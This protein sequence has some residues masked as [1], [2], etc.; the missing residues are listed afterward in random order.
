MQPIDNGAT[1]GV[2]FTTMPPRNQDG[3]RAVF[4]PPTFV[5]DTDWDLDRIYDAQSEH[6]Q[7]LFY[8]SGLLAQW[9]R[10]D[11]RLASVLDTRAASVVGLPFVV[12]TASDDPGRLEKKAAKRLEQSWTQIVPEKLARDVVEWVTLMGFCWCQ[13]HWEV[14]PDG[15]WTPRLEPWHPMWFRYDQYVRTWQVETETGLHNIVPNQGQWVLFSARAMMPWLSGAVLSLSIPVLV[16]S[17]TWKD[18]ANFNET[19]AQAFLKGK[20]P[21]WA[22]PTTDD[23]NGSPSKTTFLAQLVGLGRDNRHILC[24]VD[25]AGNGYD[26]TYESIN[27]EGFASFEK[28]RQAADL[29]IAIRIQGQNLTTEMQSG[30]LAGSKT[31]NTVRQDIIESDCETLATD[32]HDGIAVPFAALNY[33]DGELA[34]WA[35]WNP[36]PPENNKELALTLKDLVPV[37]GTLD[38]LLAPHGLQIALPL[39][40][41]KLR[42]PVVKRTI[43][44]PQPIALP[45]AP[46]L[47]PVP[48]Q[49]RAWSASSADA[50]VMIALYPSPEIAALLALRSGEKPEHLHCT[51]AYLGR[52]AEV[53]SK[54]AALQEV[55]ARVAARA[56][57]YMAEIGGLGR[58]SNGDVDV[59][60]ASVECFG[61]HQLYRS[62]C[63]ELEEIG[64]APR[65]EHVFSPHITLAYLD[66]FTESPIDRVDRF[67]LAFAALSLVVENERLDFPFRGEWS[68]RIRAPFVR[69]MR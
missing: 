1:N 36:E 6:E 30:S 48:Q 69:S 22:N 5:P 13:L 45:T 59:L 32:T 37:L 55:V 63:S 18:W 24:E 26:A 7:G 56:R 21:A 19:L 54:A 42:L 50:R 65:G 61:L 38:T 51:L 47:G 58:F 9:M 11:A 67:P 12:E 10:R 8:L 28:A 52:I 17:W 49:R 43:E 40:L 4:K 31:Q 33:G 44:T 34:P 64:L 27:G 46:K 20:V 53:E 16:R 66:R 25:S 57:P 29:E 23:D 35:Y 3:P 39:L 41:E 68:A 62:L 14:Q 2:K 60:Y 15:V